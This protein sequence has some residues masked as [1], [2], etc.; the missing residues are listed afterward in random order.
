MTLINPNQL[1]D[2]GREDPDQLREFTALIHSGQLFR[3]REDGLEPPSARAE[4]ILAERVHCEAATM[5][6]NGT[7]GLELA[8]RTIGVRPGD[9]V[10]VSAYSFIACSMAIVNVGALPVPLDMTSGLEMITPAS[11]DMERFAAAI[12]V[13]VQ[14]HVIEANEFFN[15]CSDRAIPVIEDICQAFGA[16]DA[17]G[18]AAGSRGR[19]AVTSFQQSKQLSAGEGGA[20][21]GNESDI[22]SARALADLGAVRRDD[23]LPDWDDPGARF[24]TNGRLSEIQAALVLDQLL[25]FETTITR[26]RANRNLLWDQ[27]PAAAAGISKSLGGIDTGSHTLLLAESLDDAREFVRRLD[28]DRVHA[29]VVWARPFPE[30]GVYRRPDGLRWEPSR[31]ANAASIAPRILSVPTSKYLSSSEVAEIGAAINAAADLLTTEVA[32]GV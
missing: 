17:L 5:V 12:V 9:R 7:F 23:G 25:S 14:G 29:R 30:Y 27:S 20:I 21:M 4:S 11:S 6:I 26:Q 28:A 8:L 10:A 18:S 31:Y 16:R 3:Y 2:A 19:V 32:Q 24:G 1:F 15:W 22:S 13:H